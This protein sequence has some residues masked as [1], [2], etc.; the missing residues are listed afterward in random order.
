MSGPSVP[1]LLAWTGFDRDMSGGPAPDEVA[2]P[3]FSTAALTGA[4]ASRSDSGRHAARRSAAL[5]TIGGLSPLIRVSR[6]RH[7]TAGVVLVCGSVL[8]AAVNPMDGTLGQHPRSV[9]PE[10]APGERPPAALPGARAPVETAAVST[11]VSAAAPIRPSPD[12]VAGP[13]V[14]HTAPPA[15]AA[16]AGSAGASGVGDG[17]AASPSGSTP[18]DS[19]PESSGTEPAQPPEGAADEQRPS[20]IGKVTEPVG[21]V[22]EPVERVVAPVTQRVTEPVGEVTELVEDAGQPAMSMLGSPLL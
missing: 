15:G 21:K 18:A 6:A 10:V 14:P 16:A 19:E 8:V 4:V 9:P 2:V 12:A 13:G 17:P 1:A 11:P 3:T 22:T 7:V 5:S 20:P